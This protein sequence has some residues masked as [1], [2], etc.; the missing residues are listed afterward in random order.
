[1]EEVGAHSRVRSSGRGTGVL[2]LLPFFIFTGFFLIWPVIA[3]TIRSFHGNK[4]EW[5]LANYRPILKSGPYLHAFVVSLKLSIVTSLIGS[6]LGA[7]FAY[8]IAKYAAGKIAAIIDSISAVFANSGGVPLAFMFVAAFGTE[9]IVTKLLKTIG[10]DIYAGHFTI[11]SF[12]GVVMV[13]SFFQVPL[14][15]LVFKPAISGMRKEW[16]EA[17]INLGAS[18]ATYWRRVGIPILTPSFIGAFFLLFAGGFSA[19]ATA[20]ALTVG[21]VPLVPII[22]GTLVDGNVISDQTN[23]GDA[24]A[25]GMIVVAT[26]AMGGYIFAARKAA[27]WRSS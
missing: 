10:W 16:E 14:M 2:P 11:F 15:V 7:L 5:T 17:S 13:Y 18:P 6:L 21:T 25:V 12:T 4:N 19:Y 27:R 20:R 26:I 3:V 22:I 8:V 9:G 23:L 1:M 24:L